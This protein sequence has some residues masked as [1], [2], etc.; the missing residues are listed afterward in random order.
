MEQETE[1]GRDELAAIQ[2]A[3]L[4]ERG[5]DEIR[6]LESNRPEPQQAVVILLDSMLANGED[7]NLQVKAI[8]SLLRMSEIS[9]ERELLG[10]SGCLQA[11]IAAMKNFPDSSKIANSGCMLL[12][13]A[14]FDSVENKGRIRRCRGIELLVALMSRREFDE[15]MQCWAC[16]A[17]RNLTNLSE[18][19]QELAGSI[20]SLEVLHRVL[21][22]FDWNKTLQTQGIAAIA[23]IACGG[24]ES[25]VRIRDSGC[26]EVVID[27]MK[28][29]PDNMAIQEQC[30]LALQNVCVKNGKNQRT[31]GELGGVELLTEVM[32]KHKSQAKLLAMVC[33]TLRY[34]C[35]E[36]KIRDIV[37]RNGALILMLDALQVVSDQC[38]AAE[39]E[40]VLKALTNATFSPCENKQVVA[41]CGGVAGVMKVLVKYN[42]EAEVV[43]S[44]LRVFRNVSDKGGVNCQVLET[45]GVF[46]YGLER[47]ESFKEHSGI[48]EHAFA[49]V[50]NGIHLQYDA[51]R[52]GMSLGELRSLVI[53]QMSILPTC[54]QVHKLGREIAELL[55]KFEKQEVQAP[56]KKKRTK[57]VLE[58]L[59]RVASGQ[60]TMSG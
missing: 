35:F 45:E 47:L 17:L 60:R 42:D 41:R 22:R 5:D 4:D 58:K 2:N 26:I 48:T 7:E 59:K 36:E 46:K 28:M 19:N 52:V 51:E 54:V 11:A 55:E 1:D 31:V 25:Q 18:E 38:G 34:M 9:E 57:L 20:G 27:A 16:V 50:V 10:S 56:L 12:A 53:K 8:I 13:N 37:G 43:E 21:R 40:Q 23:N 39:V 14:A 29:Y 32:R 6:R 3:D 15:E 44:G 33:S 49:I 30:V 24:L